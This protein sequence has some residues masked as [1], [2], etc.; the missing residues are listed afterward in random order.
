MEKH[1][2]SNLTVWGCCG[3]LTGLCVLVLLFF[4]CNMLGTAI[5]SQGS[6]RWH[7]YVELIFNNNGSPILLS[8]AMG[9]VGIL[10]VGLFLCAKSSSTPPRFRRHTSWHLTVAFMIAWMIAS[11]LFVVSA[12]LPP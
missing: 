2:R 5:G 7:L 3:V 4:I 12:F 6:D 10:S 11:T 9:G 8:L 1:F